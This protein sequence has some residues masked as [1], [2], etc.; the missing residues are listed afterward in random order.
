LAKRREQAGEW[1]G[2]NLVV[3]LTNG[4]FDL[5][6]PGH[7]ASIAAAKQQCD[8]LI[9]ALNSDSSVKRLKGDSRPIQSQLARAVVLSALANVD[10]VV[11]FDE[12]ALAVLDAIK[13]DI[14]CKGE[15]YR[16]KK[17]AEFDLVESY[18]GRI[19]L[20]PMVPG[21]STTATVAQ[22]AA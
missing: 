22:M 2:Q 4:C 1:R 12:D 6:H 18:G 5:L 9:I 11:I 15:D 21:F 13:P 17:I 20:I 7:I 3:G 14:Y 16:G 8:R 10:G 19:D